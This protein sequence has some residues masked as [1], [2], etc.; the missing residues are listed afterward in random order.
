MAAVATAAK[1]RFVQRRSFLYFWHFRRGKINKWLQLGP[2]LQNAAA[3]NTVILPA[4]GPPAP[5]PE[6][7]PAPSPGNLVILIRRAK[8][9]RRVFQ[10]L[11]LIDLAELIGPDR[12]TVK[13]NLTNI[14]WRLRN[15]NVLF[16][17]TVRT[18]L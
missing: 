6:P 12:A 11:K 2:A 4:P 9:Y 18:M 17:K 13:T 1:L 15:K 8:R 14:I 10:T 3:N 16:V 7:P 5:L